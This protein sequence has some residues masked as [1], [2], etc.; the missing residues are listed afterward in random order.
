MKRK[1]QKEDSD[2]ENDDEIEPANGD[3]IEQEMNRVTNGNEDDESVGNDVAEPMETED[4]EDSGEVEIEETAQNGEREIFKVLGK[5]EMKN[6]EALK[7]TSSWVQ[8]ATTFSAT[9][10]S[11]TSQKLSQIELPEHLTVPSAISTWFPVQYAVLPSL[12]FEIRSP[13]PLRPRDVA[14]AA[15]TGS[16]KTIC[17]VLPV[18][19]AVGSKPSKILQAVILVPVQTLVAQIVD[20]FKRWNDESGVAKVVSLSGANDFEKEARQL[21]SDPPNVI[22]ATPARLVQHLTSKIPPPIDLSKLRFLIVDEADRMGKLM[23]EEW[24]DLVEFLCGG[25]ERVACLKDIIRQRRAP[26]K[27]VL[28]A[29]LSKD[30][31]ELHLWNLFKPRLFSATAVSVKDITSG[32]PQVDHVSGRLALPSSISHRLVVTDPKFHPLAVYQQITRN[33]FNRTLIFVNEVS[34]SN[35]LAHVLKELCKDQFEVD[36]FT[37]Q[38]FGKRRYKMLEKFNKNENRVLICSDVLARGTDLNKVDCVINYNLPADDKL[39]VHRAGRTG[40]AGQDG[41]VISV[42]DKE[43]KRLFVKMLKVTNLW[44]D[45]VEEQMEEYIFEK[46]MDRYSKALESLKATVSSQAKTGGS[47]QIAKRSGF[48]AKR[49]SRPNAR[50]EK[51]WLKKKTT[52]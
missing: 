40:R 3:G 28:S 29:T 17:Y 24:L 41:Y 6:L 52:E 51:P 16:G 12:F 32:I 14:I 13:P 39:F 30:V 5:Q 35:R 4:V 25:M 7:V 33:K 8:N 22:V 21:A 48:E 37:A 26:Q 20:E 38:L 2:T 19:A 42:G 10:D 46:D 45:T 31:E 49:K 18:L 47:R 43:S 15:P 9:I 23:R 36:Y 11:S 1:N 27:I 34:S 44:G 50:G